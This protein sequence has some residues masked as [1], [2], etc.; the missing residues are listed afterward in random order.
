[1]SVVLTSVLNVGLVH[2]LNQHDCCETIRMDLHDHLETYHIMSAYVVDSKAEL[3][4][5]LQDRDSATFLEL[6]LS[7]T[8]QT[9]CPTPAGSALRDV[10]CARPAVLGR[11]PSRTP[12]A[13]WVYFWAFSQPELLNRA[14]LKGP[15]SD[16]LT[17]KTP[18][19]TVYKCIVQ[20]S[21]RSV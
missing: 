19:S 15:F 2:N 13:G 11:P 14:N 21:T 10:Q 17:R 4:I 20:I 12:S 16:V 3:G 5:L 7:W 9:S 18:S 6:F 1:M 8:R